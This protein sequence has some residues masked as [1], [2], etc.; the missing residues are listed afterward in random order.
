MKPEPWWS[1]TF[2]IITVTSAEAHSGSGSGSG[3]RWCSDS[4]P[5]VL[6]G[7]ARLICQQPKRTWPT[8]RTT[9]LMR[10]WTDWWSPSRRTP[11][12]NQPVQRPANAPGST[13]SH[14]S[15]DGVKRQRSETR[16]WRRHA[17][18]KVL[19]RLRAETSA[20][21]TWFRLCLRPNS[22]SVFTTDSA[23]HCFHFFTKMSSDDNHQVRYPAAELVPESMVLI[24][25]MWNSNICQLSFLKPNRNLQRFI[26]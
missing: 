22:S 8:F 7:W 13:G 16:W 25:H 4:G 12:T 11:Q 15:T 26:Y 10:S 5:Q 24:S 3:T 20:G 1:R 14:V 19:L 9:P 21:W 23:Y 2:D 17:H 18:E 6:V